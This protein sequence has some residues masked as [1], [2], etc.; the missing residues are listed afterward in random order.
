MAPGT[1]NLK[2]HTQGDQPAD[3]HASC[4]GCI[5]RCCLPLLSDNEVHP[6]NYE[7]VTNGNP[8]GIS[9]MQEVVTF[10]IL[11]IGS[12]AGQRDYITR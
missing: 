7:H 5:V 11:G 1:Q 12:R 2:V 8:L 6:I 3:C 10:C 9:T 4:T